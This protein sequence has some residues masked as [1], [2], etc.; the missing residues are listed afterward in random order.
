MSTGV[1]PLVNTQAKPQLISLATARTNIKTSKLDDVNW[2]LN[3][4]I[5]P[6]ESNFCAKIS[7]NS[8]MFFNSF[9]NITEDNNTLKVM[10]VYKV[11]GV[12]GQQTDVLTIAKG[13]YNVAELVVA[14]NNLCNTSAGG[15]IYGMASVSQDAAAARLTIVG[16]DEAADLGVVVAA[17][18][19]LGFYFVWDDETAEC[20]ELMGFGSRAPGGGYVDIIRIPNLPATTVYYGIG[21]EYANTG[22]GSDYTARGGGNIDITA[23]V[24]SVEAS[25]AFDL[26]G[27][28]A[29]NISLRG[30][31]A[32]LRS[33]AGLYRSETIAVVPVTA[34]F[35][36]KDIFMP[37][38]PFKSV[39]TDLS[40]GSF[41][42]IIEDAASGKRVDFNGVGY[43]INI[44]VE[45]F[46]TDNT[47][48][49]DLA[50][51]GVSTKVM[52]MFHHENPNH[53][54]PHSGYKH[55]VDKK[56]RQSAI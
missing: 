38:N 3:E 29:L 37:P 50:L 15:I 42:I 51:S 47:Q 5:H 9:R 16:F 18:E 31:R 36:R 45:W 23:G 19:Y 46:E 1:I 6:P 30:V 22:V 13:N 48:K 39:T 54:L 24:P 34:Q 7:V 40:L 43:V 32:D 17:H 12:I 55:P 53:L 14:I 33:G 52:P 25:N 49:S 27:I 11:N 26:A 4:P 41:N 28:P 20:L 35:G 2:V 44:E 56:R 21:F 10:S 8:M